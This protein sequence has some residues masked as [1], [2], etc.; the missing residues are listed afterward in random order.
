MG[1]G[2]VHKTA[3][4]TWQIRTTQNTALQCSCEQETDNSS[5]LYWITS[6]SSTI[7]V[8]DNLNFVMALEDSGSRTA[9]LKT[10]GTIPGQ[11]Q[12][13]VPGP[14]QPT[15]ILALR[16]EDVDGALQAEYWVLI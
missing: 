4:G 9:M 8:L 1:T 16:A 6:S 5:N 14:G 7:S 13:Q 12:G 10:L 3:P 15:Q 11:G 2:D